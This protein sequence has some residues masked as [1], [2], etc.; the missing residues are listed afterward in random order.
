[1][2]DSLEGDMKT[3]AGKKEPLKKALL[4]GDTGYFSE[5]NLREAAERKINVLI[6][7]PQFRRR[8]P[9]FAEKKKG[10]A[11]KKR[12]TVEGFACNKKTDAYK[13]PAGKALGYKYG[14]TLRNNS[15]K[16][17]RAK[18][19]TRV[20]CPLPEKCANRRSGK[21]PARTLYIIDKKH[22]GNLS[23][24]MRKKIGGPACRELYSRRVRIIEPVYSDITYCK[25][26][27]RFT[28]RT[29]E[30]VNTQRLLF[31]IVHNIGKCMKALGKR[32]GA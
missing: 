29:R 12:F 9:Y 8:D 18:R 5:G 7:G 2:L 21:N 23:E 10:K 19:G 4:E 13:C 17:Y 6:P 16:Q 24:K 11:P 32:Y 26:M 25:G 20:N 1:M 15:G 27:D 3:V 28:L 30:K 14:V 22:G 31:R